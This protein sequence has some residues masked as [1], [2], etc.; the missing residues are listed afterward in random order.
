MKIEQ[1]IVQHLYNSK[2]VTLQDIGTFILS[3]DVTIP[4]EN[5]KDSAM[6]LNAVSFEFNKKAV[7]DE[8]LVSFIVSQTRK[9]RPLAASDLESYSL[10]AKQFLNIGKPFPIEGLGVLQ[11]KQEG[12]YEFIQGNS[13]NARLEA[14]PAQLREKSEEEISFSTPPRETSG[15]NWW[16]WIILLV[17]VGAT[18]AIVYYFLKKD[19]KDKFPEQVV[20]NTDSVV[21]LKDTVA[22]PPIAK[23][24]SAATTTAVPKTDSNGFKIV[25]KEF[26]NKIAAESFYNKYTNWG[27]KLVLYSRDSVIYKIAVTINRPLSDTLHVKDS[28]RIFYNTKTY[29]ESN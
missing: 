19:N 10:L 9:I 26:T 13:I 28:L 8:E 5:D 24:D 20:A 2:K 1:L 15:K 22:M 11:K 16:L 6:P 17:L 23:V 12:D 3:P 18:S 27:H 21:K 7:Q 29:V 4:V 25:I 14:V